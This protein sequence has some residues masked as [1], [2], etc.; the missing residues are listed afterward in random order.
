MNSLKNTGDQSMNFHETVQRALE[1][2]A[3]Q[4]EKNLLMA[5][6]KANDEAGGE[7]N[8]PAIQT[9]AFKSLYG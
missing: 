5:C 1:I 6:S 2:Y 7:W 8:V 3:A 9:A 4:D